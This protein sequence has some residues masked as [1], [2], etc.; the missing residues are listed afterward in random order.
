MGSLIWWLWM[1]YLYPV[2]ASIGLVRRGVYQEKSEDR[3][4]S[5][6]YRNKLAI[7]RNLWIATGVTMLI[8]PEIHFILVATLFIT[9][10]SFTIL[11]ETG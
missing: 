11:D 4:R 7:V 10:L 8:I 6:K 1:V 2:L 5:I 3:R 9:F